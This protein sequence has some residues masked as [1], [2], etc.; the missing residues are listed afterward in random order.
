MN[1]IGKQLTRFIPTVQTAVKYSAF[2]I[3]NYKGVIEASRRVRSLFGAQV[4]VE[5]GRVDGYC[6]GL[7]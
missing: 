5:G 4:A 2:I 3:I 6:D 1:Q 7:I